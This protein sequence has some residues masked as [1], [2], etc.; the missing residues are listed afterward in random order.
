MKWIAINL[1]LNA[2]VLA[3]KLKWV[4][5]RWQRE[6]RWERRHGVTGADHSQ[7]GAGAGQ[8]AGRGPF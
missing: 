8:D 7:P 3:A 4:K 2:A 1:A 6:S 5:E